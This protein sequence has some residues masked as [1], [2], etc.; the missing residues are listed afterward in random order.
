MAQPVGWKV[1]SQVTDQTSYDG[2]GNTITG[3]NVYF[4]TGSG[5]QGVVFVPNK[6]YDKRHVDTIKAMLRESATLIDAV[7][8]LSENFD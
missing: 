5:N 1:T 6:I 3:T 2:A 4:I 7:G 8:A